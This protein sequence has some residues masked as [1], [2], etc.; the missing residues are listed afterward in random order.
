MITSAAVAVTLAAHHARQRGLT[1]AF[2]VVALIFI[3]T[4]GANVLERPEGVKITAASSSPPSSPC[5]WPPGLRAPSNCGSPRSPSTRQLRFSSATQ[6][7]E[8]SG[9]S[10]TNPTAEIGPSTA[11]NF[12]KSAA[13]MT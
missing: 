8:P 13:T 4:T 2:G 12:A 6:P 7:A 1:I 10:P 5:P 11:T 3:Y 9:W